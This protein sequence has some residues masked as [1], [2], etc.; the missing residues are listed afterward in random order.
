MPSL[1][2]AW[3]KANARAASTWAR[4]IE[5]RQRAEQ[6]LT[7]AQDVQQTIL[8]ARHARRSSPAGRGLLQR[9]EFV[10][11]L[12]RLEPMPVVEQAKGIIMVQS[13]C[14]EAEA[15]D[16]LRRASQR[17]NVPVPELAARIVAKTA[18]TAE[19]ARSRS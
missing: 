18:E 14:G 11:L 7:Q 6:L 13:N 10:R 3:P 1:A 12:A 5:L 8:D 4:T 16:M 19:P 15:F 9:S 17:S 2:I